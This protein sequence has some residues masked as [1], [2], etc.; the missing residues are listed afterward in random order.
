MERRRN[1]PF[2]DIINSEMAKTLE[3][4]HGSP[5]SSETAGKINTLIQLVQLA[6]YGITLEIDGKSWDDKNAA[7]QP[8]GLRYRIGGGTVVVEIDP[9]Q[10]VDKNEAV[11]LH[12][13]ADHPIDE[14]TASTADF[15]I[16]SGNGSITFSPAEILGLQVSRERTFKTLKEVKDTYWPG[17]PD[18]EF[19][20]M[21]DAGEIPES[22]KET[23]ERARKANEPESEPE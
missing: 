21:M 10:K 5:Y 1:E 16:R 8:P 17:V 6:G 15:T 11:S 13:Y 9:Q 20:Q 12:A 4:W 2:F 7:E 22:L 14:Y 18:E 19:L 3:Q 23:V